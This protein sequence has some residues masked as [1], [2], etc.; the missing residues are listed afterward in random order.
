[1]S[2]RIETDNGY[3]IEFVRGLRAED[4]TTIDDPREFEG[5]RLVAPFVIRGTPGLLDVRVQFV[6]QDDRTDDVF[7]FDFSA[8][9]RPAGI[10]TNFRGRSDEL[11]GE[12]TI[13]ARL[14]PVLVRSV[15]ILN[16]SDELFDERR[17]NVREAPRG[18]RSAAPKAD[19]G[20]RPIRPMERRE[21]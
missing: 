13:P 17:R 5:P 1:M 2:V 3:E 8:V 16:L 11:R 7:N 6:H 20:P 9:L 10:F 19:F 14:F 4:L 15:Q 18:P 12:A 21:N